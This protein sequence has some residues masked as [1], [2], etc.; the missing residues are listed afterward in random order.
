MKLQKKKEDSEKKW[1]K[2]LQDENEKYNSDAYKQL[3]HGV[4]FES[5]K[6]KFLYM[7]WSPSGKVIHFGLKQSKVLLDKTGLDKAK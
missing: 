6:P 2:R 1:L 4:V 7:T 5:D 3:V